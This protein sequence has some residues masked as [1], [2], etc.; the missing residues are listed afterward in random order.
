MLLALIFLAGALHGLGP[1]HLAAITALSA[2]GGGARRLV[3]FSLRFALGHSVVIAAAGMAAHFGRNLL[4]SAW[5]LRIDQTAGAL[6]LLAGVGLLIALAFGK[7]SLHAH[8]HAHAAG[9]HRHFHL[10]FFSRAAHRH[11]HGRFAAAL[12]AL[13][14]LGG[15]RGLLAIVPIATGQTL[16]V[17]ALRIL[18]FTAGIAAA[19]VAYGFAAGP[20]L[21]F[22]ESRPH[23][24]ARLAAA[25]T[26]VFCIVAGALTLTHWKG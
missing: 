8:A 25:M 6:L 23:F 14:A 10:H 19:M 16:A 3:F 1:D 12:G 26:S 5:E 15:A 4:P 18:M 20:A 9:E 21:R 24:G 17:S 2:V 22:A 13:F 7:L 11:G